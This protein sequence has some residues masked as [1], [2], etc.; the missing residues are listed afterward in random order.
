MIDSFRGEYRFLSNFYP[1]PVLFEGILYPTAEHA[2]QAVKSLSD[3]E[4]R[5]I[6]NLPKP[7]DAKAAGRRLELRPD[8]E[9][10]KYDLMVRILR[11]KFLRTPELRHKLLATAPKE[12]VEGNT[13]G[14]RIWGQVRGEGQNLLGKALMEVRDELTSLG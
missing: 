1:A 9:L 12:L 7:V 5:R 11:A 2:F 6:R 10:N 4:R 3:T 8:W 14:D 13:W